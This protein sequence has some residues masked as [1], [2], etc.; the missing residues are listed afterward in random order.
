M[1]TT[2][3]TSVPRLTLA[4]AISVTEGGQIVNEQ[5]T[6][7]NYR[8]IVLNLPNPVTQPTVVTVLLK[9][10]GTKPSGYASILLANIF[11]VA[12]PGLTSAVNRTRHP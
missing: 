3:L 6:P 4:A 11:C 7:V 2:T 1:L 10:Q 8:Y 12:A 9:L 5:N